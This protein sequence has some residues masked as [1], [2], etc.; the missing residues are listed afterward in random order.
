MRS[1]W[2][3]KKASRK[4]ALRTRVVRPKGQSPRVEFEVFEPAT[5]RDV[6]P[7]TVSRAKARCLACN[8]VLA[9]ERVRA[10]LAAQRGGADVTFDKEG[11]RASG[12]RLLAV[13]TLKEGEAGRQYRLG[14]ERDYEAVRRAQ[15]RLTKVLDEWV[16]GGRKGLCPVP[17]EPLPPIGTLG[18]RVQRYGMLRW[19]DLFTARQL[20]IAELLGRVVSQTATMLPGGREITATALSRRTDISNSLCVWS[21]NASQVVHLFG[22]QA[23]PMLWD[24]AESC[25]LGEQ[26][27]DYA[28]TLGTI[29]RVAEALE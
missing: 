26:A 24:F 4:R 7:G 10:Q 8:T 19:G 6:P 27:G 13:V 1:F 15:R 12:A 14:T 11:G 5:E 29:V 3:C 25:P 21:S 20:L 2:L 22:R 23:I 17:D 16:T 18:F 9:P 28:T